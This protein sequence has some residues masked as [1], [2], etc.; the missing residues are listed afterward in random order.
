VSTGQFISRDPL[1]SVTTEPY[2][3]VY[4]SPLNSADASGL[5]SL[6][7]IPLPLCSA[8]GAL[9]GDL[10]GGAFKGNG[11]GPD[12]MAGA[13]GQFAGFGLFSHDRPRGLMS[14]GAY[15]STPFGTDAYPSCGPNGSGDKN[16]DMI[17]GGS[18]GPGR[19]C[20]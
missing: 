17:G 5:C 6:R 19:Q 18:A 8:G 4:D 7:P 14:I 10:G 20:G 11:A 2:A 12:V 9:S 16:W 15:N 1:T 3:N 13:K